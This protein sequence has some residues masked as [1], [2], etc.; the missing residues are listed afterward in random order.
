[1]MASEIVNEVGGGHSSACIYGEQGVKALDAG[2][3]IK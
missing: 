1:M 2:E 3:R